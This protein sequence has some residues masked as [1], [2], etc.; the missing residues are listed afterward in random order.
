MPQASSVRW[1]ILALLTLAGFVMYILKST[2]PISGKGL[3]VELGLSQIQLG[4][5]IGALSFGYAVFQFPGGLVGDRFGAR[6]T[7]TLMAVAWGVLTLLIGLVPGRSL[8]TAGVALSGLVGLQFLLGSAQA[9][10]YPITGGGTTSHWFPVAGWAFPTGLQNAGL[11]LGTAATGPLVAWI[12]E[13]FGWRQ[14]FFFTAPLAFGLAVLWRWYVRDSPSEH[15]G[16][17]AQELALIDAGRPSAE[18]RLSAAAERALWKRLLRDRN[19]LLL[20]LS[21]LL[22]NCVFYF[23]SSWLFIY[24]VDGRRFKILESGFYNSVPWLTGTVTAVLGGLMCDRLSRRQGMRGGCRWTA[25]LGLVSVA[26][27]MAAASVTRSPFVAVALLSLALGSQQ[28]TDA[29]Y[30]AAT[31]SVSR[32]HASAACGVLN[33]GGNAA[34]SVVALAVPLIVTFLGWGAALASGALVALASAFMWVWIRAD[35]PLKEA[36]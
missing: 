7:M 6:R 22:N 30:W 5:I 9:P 24:L 31:I 35:E 19:V 11:T 33:T 8:A 27:F 36:A 2:M 12:M 1:R 4:M 14:G 3:M 29:A 18:A 13:R 16:V 34:G 26:G 23:F 21:Y 15:P 10:F 28:F 32:R 17:N 20:T 25:V